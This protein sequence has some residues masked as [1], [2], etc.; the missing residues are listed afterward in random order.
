[1]TDL[2]E[3]ACF[4]IEDFV[5]QSVDDWLVQNG[6]RDTVHARRGHQ[7]PDLIAVSEREALVIEAKGHTG[8]IDLDYNTGLGQ[9]IKHMD[10]EEA[11]YAIA[12]P[13]SPQFRAQLEKVRDLARK[14][15]L[16]KWLL[17]PEAGVTIWASSQVGACREKS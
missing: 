14:R 12:V 9:L 6:Y 13:D 1:M 10:S 17:S 7:D 5:V 3:A 11:V 16:M 8:G 4:P 2:N 15:L